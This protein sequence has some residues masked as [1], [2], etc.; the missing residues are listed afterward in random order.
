MSLRSKLIID[1]LNRFNYYKQELFILLYKSI[2][3][4]ESLD[5]D[6]RFFVF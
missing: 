5:N 6:F 2:I 1:K 3:Y 4:D